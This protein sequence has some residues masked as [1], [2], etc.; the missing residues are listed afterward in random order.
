MQRSGITSPGYPDRAVYQVKPYYPEAFSK[1]FYVYE[2]GH[3]W[4][5]EEWHEQC[6]ADGRYGFEV[7]PPTRKAR[8]SKRAA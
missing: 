7:S 5:S 4:P 6:K 1:A 2:A 8:K 3:F